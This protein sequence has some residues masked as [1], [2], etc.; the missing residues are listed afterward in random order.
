MGGKNIEEG[1]GK[2]RIREGSKIQRG[3]RKIESR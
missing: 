1:G 3:K 2:K